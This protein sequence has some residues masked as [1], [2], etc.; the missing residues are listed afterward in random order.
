MKTR[1]KRS[2]VRITKNSNTKFESAS[3]QHRGRKQNEIE[4]IKHSKQFISNMYS[5]SEVNEC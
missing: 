5:F 2:D 1:Q 3:K 4:F